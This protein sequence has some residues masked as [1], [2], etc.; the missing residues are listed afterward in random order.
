MI[1]KMTVEI[2]VEDNLWNRDFRIFHDP[3]NPGLIIVGVQDCDG[4]W[5]GV[6]MHPDMAHQVAEVIWQRVKEARKW[7]RE[8]FRSMLRSA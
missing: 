4:R 2:D 3:D 7:D 5:F 1:T 6:T 8:P